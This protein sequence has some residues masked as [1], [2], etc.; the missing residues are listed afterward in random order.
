MPE[1]RVNGGRYER[2]RAVGRSL[3]EVLR[4]DLGLTGT[5]IACFE[6]HCGA[7][8]VQ[9]DGVP[10]LSCIT[11]VA[12]RRGPRGHDDRG[13][14]RASARRRVRPHRRRSSAASAR[15]ADRLGG[16]ARRSEPA[17]VARGDPARD[18]REPLPLRHLSQDRGGNSHVAR[19][20]RTEKEV[21]GRYEDVWLVVEEDPLDQWPDGP[22]DV[23]GRP[24]R[25]RTGR[26]RAPAKPATR[27][28]SSFPGCSTPRCS[29]RHTRTHGSSGATP[30]A[31]K[32]PASARSSPR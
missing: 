12:H 6:G 2:R 31:P 16:R 26:Q 19:L 27:Q 10:M 9:V 24:A 13:A 11:L 22:L 20:I 14:A 3:A 5:K 1:L 30:R 29:A 4:E 25:G 18:G 7:C 17:T 32:R 8:T 23:V 28:T 21:E 15:R